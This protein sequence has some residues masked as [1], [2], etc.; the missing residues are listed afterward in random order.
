MPRLACLLL[1]LL[2]ATG[3]PAGEAAAVLLS[4]GDGTGNTT[5]PPDNPGF[6]NVGLRGDLTCIYLGNRWV[7]TANHAG[8]GDVVLGGVLY[9]AVIG[10]KVRL[11]NPDDSNADLQMF[12]LVEQ[13]PC[14]A[15][16]S[17]CRR[18]PSRRP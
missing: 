15:S 5:A 1:T 12:K 16:R 3:I 14:R 9:T 6:A 17:R 13:P 8:F 18:R 4:A 11:K 10:S 7:L 2:L